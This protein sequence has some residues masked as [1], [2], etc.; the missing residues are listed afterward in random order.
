MAMAVGPAPMVS[1]GIACS[2]SRL[3]RWGR[4]SSA[5]RSSPEPGPA[6]ETPSTAG[7]AARLRLSSTPAITARVAAP[8]AALADEPYRAQASGVATSMPTEGRPNPAMI[9]AGGPGWSSST[10]VP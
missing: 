2:R 5:A 7:E 10:I 9:S 3:R 4:G 8:T 6:S 1:R